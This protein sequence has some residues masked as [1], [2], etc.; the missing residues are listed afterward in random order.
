MENA[1]KVIK[2]SCVL[3]NL[4]RERDGVNFEDTL[5]HN[6]EP[7][8]FLHV[9]CPRVGFTIGDAFADYFLSPA[10]APF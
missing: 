9:C 10:G 7:A 5:A 6:M 4:V 1:C 8:D 3:H 2:A